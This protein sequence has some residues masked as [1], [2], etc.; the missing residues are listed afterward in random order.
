MS[1][2][3]EASGSK[4][5]SR[6]HGSTVPSAHVHSASYDE[7]DSAD[8]TPAPLFDV[9]APIAEQP[10]WWCIEGQYQVY[11][12]VKLLNN[13]RVMNQTLTIE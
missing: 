2:S 7:A 1:G 8:S 12:D 4:R 3:E 13:K 5:E 10:N 6:W 11:R 9:L